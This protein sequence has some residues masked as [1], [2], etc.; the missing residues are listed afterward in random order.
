MPCLTNNQDTRT[1][2]AIL[3]VLLSEMTIITGFF[4]A[5]SIVIQTIVQQTL[6][7]KWWYALRMSLHSLSFSE[8]VFL[9]MHEPSVSRYRVFVCGFRRLA[10]S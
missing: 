5:L 10:L 6:E 1:D 2:I 7:G 8:F 9:A 3:L 4:L